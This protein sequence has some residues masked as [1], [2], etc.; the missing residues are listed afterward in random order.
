MNAQFST[1]LGTIRIQYFLFS[2][3][4]ISACIWSAMNFMVA[5]VGRTMKIRLKFNTST[6]CN[7]FKIRLTRKSIKPLSYF[8]TKHSQLKIMYDRMWLRNH[9]KLHW[10][11][12]SPVPI[13]TISILT[14]HIRDGFCLVP[15]WKFYPLHVPVQWKNICQ[16]LEQGQTQD[17]LNFDNKRKQIWLHCCSYK[18]QTVIILQFGSYESWDSHVLKLWVPNDDQWVPHNTHHFKRPTRPTNE[19]K[20]EI[21][22]KW[23]VWYFKIIF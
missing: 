6:Q 7:C 10:G 15:A 1:F 8:C 19:H 5:I 9:K 17:N 22:L 4:L 21:K 18:A 3:P 16:W 11:F 23:I 20:L 2:P 13:D 14:G 12:L